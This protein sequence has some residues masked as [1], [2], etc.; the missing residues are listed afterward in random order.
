MRGRPAANGLN[1]SDRDRGRQATSIAV[2]PSPARRCPH[3]RPPTTD[4]SSG[5]RPAARRPVRGG[6]AVAVTDDD[7]C[8]KLAI[9]NR[10]QSIDVCVHDGGL[11]GKIRIG[12]L[13]VH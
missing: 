10:D 3:A 7:A 11:G 1:G 4:R 8:S 5:R 2:R 9:C 13:L 12:A 6:C